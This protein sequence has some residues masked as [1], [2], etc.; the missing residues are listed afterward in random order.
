MKRQEDSWCALEAA[1]FPRQL[2]TC[3]D[4]FLFLEGELGSN[5]TVCLSMYFP[6][7]GPSC[8]YPNTVHLS[9]H[10]FFSPDCS[11]PYTG[12]PMLGLL[13]CLSL[14]VTLGEGSLLDMV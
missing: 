11:I 10:S 9:L 8:L 4:C 7:N 14:F 2:F 5:T 6:P 13:L 12:S 3:T 1:A